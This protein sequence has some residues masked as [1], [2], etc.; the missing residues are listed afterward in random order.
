MYLTEKEAKGKKCP[1]MDMRTHGCVAS[2]CMAW[3]W[4]AVK[5]DTINSCAVG[6][7]LDELP[8]SNIPEGDGWM[9]H[10][11]GMTVTNGKVKWR[12]DVY[13]KAVAES[14]GYCGLAGRP[15]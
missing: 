3:R 8:R 2:L 9:L 11:V 13:K 1:Q 12:N 10:S 15:E 14:R 5:D 7:V 6:D 4:E